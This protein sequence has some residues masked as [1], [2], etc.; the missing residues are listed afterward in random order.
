M[1]FSGLFGWCLLGLNFFFWRGSI[2]SLDDNHLNQ[3]FLW[4]RFSGLFG[5]RILGLY[6]SLII[7]IFCVKNLYHL[8]IGQFYSLMDNVSLNDLYSC[9]KNLYHLSLNDLYSCVKNLYYITLN[10]L[11]S[12]QENL[13]HLLLNDLYILCEEYKSPSQSFWLGWLKINSFL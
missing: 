6:I 13:Y 8:L 11:Y 5:R 10:D 4:K 7:H 2:A 1:R 3:L 9:I 12:C